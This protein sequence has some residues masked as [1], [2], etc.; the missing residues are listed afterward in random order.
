MKD[1]FCL[2]VA[3]VI[4]SVSEPNN[5]AGDDRKVCKVQPEVPIVEQTDEQQPA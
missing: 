4:C 3:N 5:R 1:Q 2:V